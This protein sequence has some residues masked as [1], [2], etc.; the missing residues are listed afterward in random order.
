MGTHSEASPV[1]SWTFSQG[2]TKVEQPDVHTFCK[3]QRHDYEYI[4]NRSAIAFPA[5]TML[6]KEVGSADG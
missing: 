5:C 1:R 6:L 4:E 2:C 3:V